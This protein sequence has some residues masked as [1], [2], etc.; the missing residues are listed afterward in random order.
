MT[1]VAIVIKQYS[2]NLLPFRGNY[3]GN[4]AL[5]HRMMVFPWNGSK[6]PR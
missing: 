3:Q 5:K 1:P 2:G 6:L 4:I